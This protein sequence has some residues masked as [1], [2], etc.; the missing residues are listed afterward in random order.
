LF[1][2]ARVLLNNAESV[3]AQIAGSRS[4]SDDACAHLGLVAAS[5]RAMARSGQ[6]SLATNSGRTP[7]PPAAARPSTTP[8]VSTARLP[9]PT[10][11]TAKMRATDHPHC[12][13]HPAV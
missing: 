11:K 8:T 6:F 13:R 3:T 5:G 9:W 12:S 7:S 2:N 10:T 4:G 1:S